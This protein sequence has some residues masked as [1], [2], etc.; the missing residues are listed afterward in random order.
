MKIRNDFVSNS[1]SSSF[2]IS[3]VYKI[4]HNIP[5]KQLKKAINNCFPKGMDP[6]SIRIYNISDQW[7]LTE[8]I[9]KEKNLLKGWHDR[10]NPDREIYDTIVNYLK[11]YG[12]ISYGTDSHDKTLDKAVVQTI[13]IIKHNLNIKTLLEIVNDI[14]SLVLI[15]MDDNVLWTATN[16]NTS[17]TNDYV[18]K[19]FTMDRFCELISRQLW[20]LGY[21]NV[22]YRH[23][24]FCFHGHCHQG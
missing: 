18:T 16:I 17:N 13:N 2:I 8:A 21:E 19:P 5:F 6:N 24:R 14:D 7:V 12:T 9:E 3:D 11:R 15:C 4:T 22:D 23:L 1:S 20:L 10:M